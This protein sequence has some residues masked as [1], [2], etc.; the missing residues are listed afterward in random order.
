MFT[1]F[2]LSAHCILS[3]TLSHF[4]ILMLLIIL[5]IYPL[6]YSLYFFIISFIPLTLRYTQPTHCTHLI[7]I[8]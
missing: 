3:T 5:A 7:F 8:A 2:Y 1:A 6:F 4:E